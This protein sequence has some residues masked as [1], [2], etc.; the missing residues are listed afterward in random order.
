MTEEIKYDTVT[1]TDCDIVWQVSCPYCKLPTLRVLYP[2][3]ISK[4]ALAKAKVKPKKQKIKVTKTDGIPIQELPI[5][6]DNFFIAS[7][8]Y[9]VEL[10]VIPPAFKS[11]FKSKGSEYFTNEEKTELI[12]VSDHWGYNI[13]FCAWHLKGYPK[14]TSWKW[15]KQFTK[16]KRIGLIKFTELNPN[17]QYYKNIGVKTEFESRHPF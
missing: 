7:Q 6:V 9:F 17:N 12:R 3:R 1:C 13:R 16:A 5:T 11:F 15:Q 2:K 4:K 10:L 14:V 8:G